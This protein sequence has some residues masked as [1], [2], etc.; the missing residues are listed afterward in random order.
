MLSIYLM[1]KLH[2]PSTKF[3]TLHTGKI[4]VMHNLIIWKASQ[5]S[6]WG[7]WS[8]EWK[9]CILPKKKVYSI[10][11]TDLKDNFKKGLQK[12]EYMNG[13]GIF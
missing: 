7:Q 4:P 6:T 2:I 11:Q 8:Q 9:F 5:S 3:S 1:C 12:Y 13:C 10:K